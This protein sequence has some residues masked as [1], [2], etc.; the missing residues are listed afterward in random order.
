M[1]TSLKNHDMIVI[2]VDDL[3]VGS[4]RLS[5]AA[6]DIHAIIVGY[7]QLRQDKIFLK[8]L[9]RDETLQDIPL[10]LCLTCHEQKAP[11]LLKHSAPC[12]FL[13][14]PCED[15]MLHS[16][17]VCGERELLQRRLLRQQIQSRQS[18]IGALRRGIFRLKNFEQAEALT[19]MLSLACPD[20]DRVAFGLFELLANSIEHGNL[21]IGS[22]EKKQLIEKNVRQTEINRRLA[23][24]EYKDKYVEVIFERDKDLVSFRIEDQGQ[25]FDY[26]AYL[27]VDL[28]ANQ[29]YQG[30]GI[31]L[32]RATSFDYLEY[33]GNGNKVLAISKFSGM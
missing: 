1:V 32:A 22:M 17:L 27:D 21:G 16:M 8:K 15:H 4:D 7:D 12:Y 25:G 18:V 9:S 31:A 24:P 26:A 30:R 11:P 28:A 5:D 33:M 2:K 20:S 23:L 29:G 10:I 14:L 13:Y 6:S 19:T 3:E